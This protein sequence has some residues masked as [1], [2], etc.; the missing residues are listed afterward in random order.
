MAVIMCM[1]VH[2]GWW[3]VHGGAWWLVVCACWC[4]MASLVIN[5]MQ[6]I[7]TPAE[8]TAGASMCMLVC[9][10]ID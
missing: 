8:K 2:N 1:V 3:Y 6:S 7:H 9:D 4:L 10:M 5:A